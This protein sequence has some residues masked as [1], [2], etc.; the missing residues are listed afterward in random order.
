MNYVIVYLNL[1][2]FRDEV[3]KEDSMPEE[4][5]T[6]LFSHIDPLYEL[7]ATFLKVNRA[8]NFT[9]LSSILLKVNLDH[10]YPHIAPHALPYNETYVFVGYR[11]ADGDLGG[12][13]QRSFTGKK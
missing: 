11:A 9:Q 5:L 7:H 3:S 13:W 10:T 1:Q 6:L 2:W 4:T 12:S 8:H